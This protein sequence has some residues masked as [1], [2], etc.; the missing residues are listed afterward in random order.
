MKF[1]SKLLICLGL[2][3]FSLTGFGQGV[4]TSTITGEVKD[5]D[6]EPLIGVTVLVKHRPTGTQTGT[7]TNASGRFTA[8]NLRVGGPY[9][10]TLSYVGFESFTVDNIFLK[11]GSNYEIDATLSEQATELSDVVVTAGGI[12]NSDRTGE[13]QAF[14]NEQIRKMPT[15]TRSAGDIYRLSPSSDGNSFAGRNDQYNNFSLDGSIFNNPFGLDAATPGGQTDAQPISLDAIEQIQV[16]VAPFDVTQSGFTG[17]S[18]NAVTKSG[19]NDIKGTV[20]GFYRSDALTGSKVEGE[21]VF[22]PELTQL[23]TGFSLGGPVIKDKLFF[24]INTELERRDDL[25]SSFLPNTGTGA[26]N[27]SRI[28]ESDLIAVQSALR[29]I[30]Y[31]PGAYSGFIHETNNHKGIIKLDWNINSNHTLVATYN[32]LDASKQKPAHP[33]ALGRRGPDATTLQ[34]QNSGYQINNIIHSGLIELR[35]LFGNKFSNKFQVGYTK[36][37]DSREPFSS[38]FPVVNI[39]QFGVRGIVAGHEPF[40]I[41]NRLDQDVLQITNNFD[42]YLGDHTITIGTSLEKFSF[43]NSFNLG[44]YEPFE[45][46]GVTP[47]YNGNVDYYPGGSFGGGFASVQAFLDFVNTNNSDGISQLENIANFSQSVFDANNANDTWAL[48]ETNVGQWAFYV[49]DRFAVNSRLNLTIGLR[50][51]L[52]LYFD[53]SEKIQENIDRSCCYDPSIVYTDEDGNPVTFDHTELPKQTPLWSPRVGFNWD[54]KGNKEIQVRGGTGL[55]TGRLPFV[56]IGNQ[57]ANPNSFFYNMTA[58]DFK[59]P[60]VWRSSL[61]VDKNYNGGWVTSLDLAYTN[62]VNAMM[63]RNYGLGGS[64]QGTLNAPGDD[65]RIYTNGQKINNAYIFTNTDKGR[66]FNASFEVKRNWENGLYTSIAYNYL[67]AK[68]VTS[69]EAEITSDAFDRNPALGDVNQTVLA[70]SIYGNKHRIVGNLNKYFNY[71][72]KWGTTISMFFEY[73]QG[74]RFSYTYAGDINNDGAFSFG[75][76]L[77]YIPTDS[78]VDAMNFAATVNPVD[79]TTVS[80]AQQQA[81]LKA[82][83]AQDDY[84]SENRG[85]YAGR[86]AALSPWY[87]RWDLRILQDYNLNNGDQIQFSVDILNVGNLVSS[88]WGVRQFPTNTQVIGASTD[89]STGDVTYTFDP[90][91]RET[92]TPDTGLLSRWQ[93][94]FGL[95]YS[96]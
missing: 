58:R 78:Q 10:V 6:G 1:Y 87:S 15:I 42:M 92:F 11:L 34:F 38:P 73:A 35:S 33:S 37:D 86:N 66:S 76:D 79:G 46:P 43:D 13:S 18:V 90:N 4:T 61:G 27:E 45:I 93:V 44:V 60:Q 57:V 47:P 28:P 17:A 41:N 25:G 94:Q 20:F 88:D 49:Q 24:F 50:M 85:S 48:A 55:F 7:I 40:S 82:Y 36:F 56:W 91:L 95:R 30:G 52:P 5:S 3:C 22:V 32:F 31:D 80:A 74:G 59:F 14:D 96:F 51:D 67:D 63:V 72:E 2:A 83:I 62:D 77:I 69:I 21:K 12:F 16:S 81:A 19:T 68:D 26:I 64:P 23:Q 75:N 89:A 71:S 8:P 65:R 53:T 54:V 29:S 39:N 84:L 70:P 9:E